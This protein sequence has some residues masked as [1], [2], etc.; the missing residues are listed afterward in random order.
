M[1]KSHQDKNKRTRDSTKTNI[2][3]NP[4]NSK[5]ISVTAKSN[6]GQ[7]PS[8]KKTIFKVDSNNH[9]ISVLKTYIQSLA[10]EMAH[11]LIIKSRDSVEN[12]LDSILAKLPQ[13]VEE[14]HKSILDFEKSPIAP[15][16][17][18]E[19]NPINTITSDYLSSENEQLNKSLN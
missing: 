1:K 11:S 13:K 6:T 7:G 4:S 19:A 14:K 10:K 3:R 12:V 5:R 2:N 18:T 9:N 17:T 16:K 15:P 8:V